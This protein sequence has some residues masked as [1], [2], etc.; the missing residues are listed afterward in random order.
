LLSKQECQAEIAEATIR[1]NDLESL[2]TQLE[3]QHDRLGVKQASE[4]RRILTEIGKI[5]GEIADLRKIMEKRKDDLA[6]W[7]ANAPVL[8]KAIVECNN[9]YEEGREIV[10]GFIKLQSDVASGLARLAEVNAG[11]SRL[12][13]TV[14]EATGEH[15]NQPYSIVIPQALAFTASPIKPLAPWRR[16]SD[17]ERAARL[18]AE[19]EARKKR[20]A[21]LVDIANQNG[22]VCERCL[23]LKQIEVKMAVDLRAGTKEEPGIA[24]LHARDGLWVFRCPRCGDQVVRVIPATKHKE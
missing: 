5:N 23:R 7:E 2:R 9:L 4:R 19:D 6:K 11:M 24:G 17:E 21:E 18:K 10:D 16:I 12:D 20:H 14:F 15:L 22:P 1:I 13:N 8:Q 3:E